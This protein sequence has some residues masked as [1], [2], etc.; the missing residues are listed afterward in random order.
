MEK[1][2]I[3]DAKKENFSD[4]Y[5][6]WLF[7]KEL[8]SQKIIAIA[9]SAGGP[10][11]LATILSKIPQ[12]FKYPIIV[13]QHMALGSAEE[14]VNWLKTKSTIPV[15]VV[16]KIKALEKGKAYICP[17]ENDWEIKPG[18]KRFAIPIKSSQLYNPS[19]DV[20]LSSVAQS[21]GEKAIGIILNGMGKDG[22]KGM[23]AIQNNGGVTIAQ[24]ET[25]SVVF[26]MNKAAITNGAID[27][28]L[29]LDQIASEIVSI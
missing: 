13:A 24:D 3:Q 17:P 18:Q 4:G 26:E 2:L 5:L 21:Y 19:C 10:K 7:R 23:M 27:K 11:A 15:E 14:F 9:C 29:P 12:D 6:E 8:E 22:V 1:K 20:L 25:T 28:V 16:Q